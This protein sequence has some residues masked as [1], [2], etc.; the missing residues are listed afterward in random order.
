[1]LAPLGLPGGTPDLLVIVVVAFALLRGPLTGM[2]VGF[3][4]G[5]MA[6]MAPP[7]DHALGRLAW[8]FCLTGYLAGLAR[9]EVDRSAFGPM[10]VV[11]FC[12][13]FATLVNAAIGG[14]LGDHR[15]TWSAIVHVLPSAIV[16]AVVAT[17]FIVP[18]VASLDRRLEP[19]AVLVKRR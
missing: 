12:A 10:V 7:A 9:D 19:D 16:Y 2:V 4:A 13:G 5:L 3:C 8:V 15:V 11:G 6:D 1:V 18:A 17:P 14:I